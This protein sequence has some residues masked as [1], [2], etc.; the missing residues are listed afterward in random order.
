VAYEIGEGDSGEG[1][2]IGLLR[3]KAAIVFNTS[4]TPNGRELEI[5]CDPLEILWKDCIFGLCGVKSFYRKMFGVIV[6]STPEQRK[7][8]LK[9]VEEIVEKYFPANTIL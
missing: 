1:I 4:N 2:P 7:E 9:H 3:A 5:F 6:T 8:W